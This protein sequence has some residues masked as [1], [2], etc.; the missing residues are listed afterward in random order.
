VVEVTSEEAPARTVG[1]EGGKRKSKE[2]H[3]DAVARLDESGRHGSREQKTVGV[4]S[5]CPP[6]RERP[7]YLLAHHAAFSRYRNPTLRAIQALT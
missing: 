3:E 5:A 2:D 1:S 4:A 6:S 7:S